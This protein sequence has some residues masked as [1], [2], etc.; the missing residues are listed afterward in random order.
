MRSSSALRSRFG[1]RVEASL[2]ETGLTVDD[3]ALRSGLPAARVERILG[4]TLVR[5]T[6]RDM[7]AIAGVVGTPLFKLLAPVG[8]LVPAVSVEEVEQRGARH[9]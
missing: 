4:G 6:L 3:L 2:A 8:A 5:L 7:T 9:A 1:Y